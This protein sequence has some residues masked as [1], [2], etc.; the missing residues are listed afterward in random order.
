[1]EN[2]Y[3][4]FLLKPGSDVFWKR[5]Y[6]CIS[7]P[8]CRLRNFLLCARDD[9]CGIWKEEKFCL[10]KVQESSSEEESSEEEST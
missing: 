2:Q 3:F 9:R 10:K 8:Q 4:C 6:A 7:C 1:M 5:Q